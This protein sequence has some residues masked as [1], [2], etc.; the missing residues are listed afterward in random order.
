VSSTRPRQKDALQFSV[1]TTQRRFLQL[2]AFFSIYS[3]YY[4]D[5]VLQIAPI[6]IGVSR[7]ELNVRPAAF[8]FIGCNIDSSTVI[9]HYSRAQDGYESTKLYAVSAV[10]PLY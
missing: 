10:T 4:L 5:L 1:T 7:R 3:V 6:F 2:H 9:E 8:F